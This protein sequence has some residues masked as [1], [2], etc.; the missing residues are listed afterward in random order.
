MRGI[1]QNPSYT[2]HVY[3]GRTTRR[4]CRKR[5]SAL[6]PVVAGTASQLK[7]AP[8]TWISVATIPA[9][10]S[11]EEFDQVQAKL[12]QNQQQ[13][14]RHNTVHTY[15]L[16]ALVSCGQCRQACT[17]RSA[18]PGYT[19]YVCN[20]KMPPLRSSRTETCPARFVPSRQLDALV[21]HDLCEV[22]M[23]PESITQA[24][25][26]AHG[27]Q[28]MPQHLQ[29]RRAQLQRGQDRLHSQ[30]ERL[31]EAYVNQVMPLEEYRRRRQ[32]VEQHLHAVARLL[33][34]LEAEARNQQN[35]AGLVES[36]EAFCARV[37]EGLTQ[38]T[39]EQKRQLVE[40]LIDRV[41]VTD[42]DVEIHYVIPT[43]PASEQVRFCH[44]RTDY[45]DTV[46]V[47]V[48]LDQLLV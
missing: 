21:W 42:A 3:G 30:V 38:A 6:R 14:A 28:W 31:T 45:F 19:Y 36:M 23:H 47:F 9:L 15:L 10:V 18:S 44:L 32:A 37:Q 34:Q 29:A 11:E 17:G 7:M 26:Q 43:T 25:E 12:A 27:G 5:F 46:L 16:R 2:G 24:L 4:P 1:L 35:L 8:A 33:D 13:A 20:G 48:G 40:L 22:L 41:V 39:W